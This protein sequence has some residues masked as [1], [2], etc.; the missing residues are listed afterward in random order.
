[1]SRVDLARTLGALALF[2]SV[3]AT[4]VLAQDEPIPATEKEQL[5]QLNEQLNKGR[6]RERELSTEEQRLKSEIDGLKRRSVTIASEIQTQEGELSRIESERDVLVRREFELRAELDAQHERLSKIL[7]VLQRMSRT[8]PPALLV[9]P[10]DATAA[11][12]SAMVLSA[13]VPFVESE[14]AKLGGTLTE[15][16]QVRNASAAR[17]GQIATENTKLAK[18]RVEVQET[19]DK[20]A[21]LVS[22][23][24]SELKTERERLRDLA[25]Q[26]ES[27]AALIQNIEKAKPGSE[28][29]VTPD[30]APVIVMSDAAASASNKITLKGSL[31]WPA[32][33][34]IKSR[35]DEAGSRSGQTKGLVVAARPG[36]QVVAPADGRIE[37]ADVYRAYGNLL[38][39]ST[40]QGYHILLSG[41]ERID[42]AVGQW[43]IAGEPVGV[44]GP[45]GAGVE[46]TGTTGEARAELY[47]ELQKNGVAI[48][49]LPWFSNQG[50][51]SG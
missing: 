50:K 9:K 20:L 44:M 39:I 32:A 34:L 45:G 30:G 6:E 18:L 22:L 2:T 46:R 26:S 8:P 37:F 33:G 49:P 13:V 5:E 23:T 19:M 25:D 10:E 31:L 35:F 29:P 4:P 36:G 28:K 40:G 51:V 41:L 1:M 27:L 42:G 48:D 38:I 47:I 43:V 15:I 14:A 12:R 3:L 7:G 24:T 17:A 21:D 11:A 16:A